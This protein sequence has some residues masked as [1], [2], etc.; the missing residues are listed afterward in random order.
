MGGSPGV[1]SAVSRR[2]YIAPPSADA[3]VWL[4]DPTGVETEGHFLATFC[5][6]GRPV[7]VSV[8]REASGRDPEWLVWTYRLAGEIAPRKTFES[9]SGRPITAEDHAHEVE[10]WQWGFLNA[11]RE[12]D[13]WH[14]YDVATQ[15]SVF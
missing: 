12:F 3:K 1:G 4:I 11:P 14:P 9:R 6:G 15:P 13:P 10:L 7:P 5:A 8:L 2:P